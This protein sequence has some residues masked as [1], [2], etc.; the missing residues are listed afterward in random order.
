MLECVYGGGRGMHFRTHRNDISLKPRAILRWGTTW[1]LGGDCDRP[2]CT[3]EETLETVSA[4]TGK[5]KGVNAF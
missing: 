4:S 2:Y 5:A 1:D 3:E